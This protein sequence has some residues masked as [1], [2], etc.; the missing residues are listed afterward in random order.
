MA[1]S[2]TVAIK[3]NFF[4][5]IGW[6]FGFFGVFAGPTIHLLVVVR[7]SPFFRRGPPFFLVPRQLRPDVIDTCLRNDGLQIYGLPRLFPVACE[8]DS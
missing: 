1:H 6:V 7:L 5:I 2:A 4:V 8:A 3:I